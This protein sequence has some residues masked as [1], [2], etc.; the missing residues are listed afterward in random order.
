M[1]IWIMQTNML[2]QMISDSIMH[3]NAENCTL[4][5]F[6]SS[7]VEVVVV[8]ALNSTHGYIGRVT[9]NANRW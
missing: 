3:N 7:S 5:A 6:F 4:R 1:L 2:T 9:T 8:P